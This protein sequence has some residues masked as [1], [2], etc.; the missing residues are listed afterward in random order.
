[1]IWR[2][3][4][5]VKEKM[6]TSTKGIKPQGTAP[7]GYAWVRRKYGDEFAQNI[8]RAVRHETAHHTSGQWLRTGSAGMEAS[9]R[10][11]DKFP[12][13]WG[14]NFVQFTKELGLTEKDFFI[15]T[16]KDSHTGAVTNYIGWRK[17]GDFIKFMAWFI[18]NVRKGNIGA[19][20]SLDPE[21]Q[22]KYMSRVMSIPQSRLEYTV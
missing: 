4:K 9:P 7:E 6:S 15:K 10:T 22:K 18:M 20:N 21:K 16:M 17:T 1:M 14:K 5:Y 2:L 3:V 8:E 11:N 13:G 12:Y 19:W